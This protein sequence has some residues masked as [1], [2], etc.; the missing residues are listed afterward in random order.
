MAFTEARAAQ[1][2]LVRF[3]PE[4]KDANDTS[5]YL[6]E[7]IQGYKVGLRENVGLNGSSMHEFKLTQGEHKGELVSIW[8]SALLDE[9]LEI[10]PMGAETRITFLGI[11]DPKKP[12]GRQY[13][14]FKVEFDATSKIPMEEVAAAKVA[15]AGAPERQGTDFFA[16]GEGQGATAPA[17]PAA[18]QPQ[19]GGGEA[20][21]GTDGY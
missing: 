1:S 15:V 16:P 11:R 5:I 7:A 6:G 21:T 13:M 3:K 14:D 17:A 9:R 19:V 4:P 18:A 20:A 10:V 12:G 8:G 2:T